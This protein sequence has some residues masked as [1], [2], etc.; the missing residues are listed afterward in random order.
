[1]T[2]FGVDFQALSA[3]S[4]QI[5]LAAE[6]F[7]QGSRTATGTPRAAGATG[8]ATAVLDRALS[9]LGDALNKAQAELQQVADHLSATVNRYQSTERALVAWRVPGATGRDG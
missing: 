7:G 4:A 2:T 1:M 5:G 9:A 3:A 6:A 8:E